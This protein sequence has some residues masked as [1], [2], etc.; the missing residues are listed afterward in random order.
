MITD[1]SVK[2]VNLARKAGFA[3]CYVGYLV[4]LFQR[5]DQPESLARFLEAFLVPLLLLFTFNPMGFRFWVWIS[6]LVILYLAENREQWP[7]LAINLL[8][9]FTLRVLP[10]NPSSLVFSVPFTRNFLLCIPAIPISQVLYFLSS[11]FYA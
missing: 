7:L 6:P 2:I 11:G 8:S 10:K 3:L 5:K 9:L 1:L 4:F